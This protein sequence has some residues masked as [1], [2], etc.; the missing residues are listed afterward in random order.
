MTLERGCAMINQQGIYDRVI[1]EQSVS[2]LNS[3][4]RL[5]QKLAE[6]VS[7]GTSVYYKAVCKSEKKLSTAFHSAL[8]PHHIEPDY[9]GRLGVCF[10]IQR[11]YKVRDAEALRILL[12]CR[13]C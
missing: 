8:P 7:S 4:L 11:I 13:S 5:S 1:S 3:N 2:R 12:N 10:V 9:K 6:S